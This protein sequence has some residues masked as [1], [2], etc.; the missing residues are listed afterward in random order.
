MDRI[1]STMRWFEIKE[2]ATR[3]S[4]EP[5]YIDKRGLVTQDKELAA[6]TYA[7]NADLDKLASQIDSIIK[8]EYP[9]SKAERKGT[10]PPHVRVLYA[11]YSEVA[12]EINQMDQMLDPTDP[13]DKMILADLSGK[14]QFIRKLFILKDGDE[15]R[16]A[17]IVFNQDTE[18]EG[19]SGGAILVAD[20]Q[21]TP[22]R[23]GFGG[24][25]FSNAD[26]LASATISKLESYKDET[27]KTA[28]IQLVEVALGKRDSVDD[29]LMAYISANKTSFNNLSK[30]FGEILTPI[31]LAKEEGQAISF[32]IGS[33]EAMIDV[34]VGDQP[35]AVKSLS[36]SGNGMDSIGDMIDAYKETIDGETDNRR[37]KLFQLVNSQRTKKS[38]KQFT[39]KVNDNLIF[40]AFSVPTKEAEEI[41]QLLGASPKN[42][43]ELVKAIQ[44]YYDKKLAN[45][46]SPEEQYKAWLEAIKPISIA[47][48]YGKELKNGKFKIQPIG[49]PADYVNYI[50]F[51]ETDGAAREKKKEVRTGFNLYKKD[52]VSEASKNIA[53]L[54]GVSMNSLYGKGG[55]DAEDMEK[56]MTDIMRNKGA[57]AAKITINKD[58]TLDLIKKAFSDLH[59]GFQY[60]AATNAPN[61]NAPGYHIIFK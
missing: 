50:N 61:R 45:L 34:T 8:Q 28:L 27:L 23:L 5:V 11:P 60:H 37:K 42:Y 47:S 17:P 7:S 44:N 54:L 35:V 52:F 43:S 26:A 53:Y 39:G 16:V 32:P 57:Y 4:A 30:D 33:N 46:E 18:K 10:K 25:E 6:R 1:N 51:D 12:D 38:G 41:Q 22:D 2:M 55:K 59:F 3:V 15:E 21:L 24:Q 49:L 40:G 20:K 36:G 14:A 31:Q 56:L 58:G 29:E 13:V 9:K 19:E 48:G